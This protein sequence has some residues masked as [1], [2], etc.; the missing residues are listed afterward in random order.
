M[1]PARELAWPT[2]AQLADFAE[3]ND[4][5][6]ELAVDCGYREQPHINREFRAFAGL[7]PGEYQPVRLD[8]A[9]AG[10]RLD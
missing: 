6:A 2:G 4:E 9:G 1:L 10:S 7:A 3:G 5:S 8:C